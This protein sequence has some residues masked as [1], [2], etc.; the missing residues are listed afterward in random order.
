MLVV[1]KLTL[2][3]HDQYE[4][5]KGDDGLINE[6][7]SYLRGM[8]LEKDNKHL[9]TLYN[10]SRELNRRA[11]LSARQFWLDQGRDGQFAPVVLPE[12]GHCQIVADLCLAFTQAEFKPLA[13]TYT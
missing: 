11:T 5:L 3:D 6:A 10:A 8:A 7:L 13:P 1:N 4:H 12:D 9:F 2:P